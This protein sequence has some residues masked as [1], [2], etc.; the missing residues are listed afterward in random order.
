MGVYRIL[1]DYGILGLLFC[2][3]WADL[4]WILGG[5]LYGFDV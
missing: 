1:T 2:D 5:Y 3:T 4:G